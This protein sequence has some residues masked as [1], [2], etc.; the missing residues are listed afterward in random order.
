MDRGESVSSRCPHSCPTQAHHQLWPGL[1]K[2]SVPT[3]PASTPAFCSSK[4]T[5]GFLSHSQSK[6]KCQ[7]RPSRPIWSPP[8]LPSPPRIPSHLSSPHHSGLLA[9]PRTSQTLSY[10]SVSALGCS[11]YIDCSSLTYWPGSLP[12]FFIVLARVS[13]YLWRLLWPP[14]VK[15][16]FIP[17]NWERGWERELLFTLSSALFF[18]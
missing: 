16:N 10:L 11:L 12:Y 2:Q 3:L 15:Y 14:Y 5:C 18:S 9:I 7:Q 4:S 17:P 13:L 8:N 1:S 6:P